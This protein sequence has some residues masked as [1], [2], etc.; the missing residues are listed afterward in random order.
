MPYL[1][2][3]QTAQD[4][5]EIAERHGEWRE[6]EA[7]DIL[8]CSS[9]KNIDSGSVDAFGVTERAEQKKGGEIIKYWGFSY[10]PLLG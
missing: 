2:T 10:G 5:V 6:E 7:K 9:C 8:A 4:I 1:N 3:A